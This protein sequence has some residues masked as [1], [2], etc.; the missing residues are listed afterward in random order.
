VSKENGDLFSNLAP[1]YE[2]VGEFYDLFADNTDIPFYIK[3]A[4][5]TGSPILDLAAGT[6]R[7]AFALAHDGH[8]VIA[9]D[10]SPS[11]LSTARK[12]LQQ[13]S[14]D[15]SGRITFIEGNM[16][17]FEIPEKFA[18]VIIPNSFGH[19][20]TTDA[21]VATLRCIKSHMKKDG[22]FILDLYIG[23]Q[24]YTHATFK[25]PAVQIGKYR[26]VERHGEIHSDIKRKLMRVDIQYI[27]KNIDGSILETIEVESG[28][29]LFFNKEIDS[30][31][32]QVGFKIIEEMG[33]LHGDS[34]NAES[35]RRV[36]IL[37]KST[38][39]LKAGD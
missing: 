29:A 2:G 4:R 33:S 6:G 15:I 22:L 32:E 27:I 30:L 24:Q 17:Q 16:E 1:G 3:C 7:I 20:L 18:L 5:R 36:L 11:M 13:V 35:G 31:L 25:D 34:Y 28:A 8:E 14:K 12:K 37:K 19:A 9:L 23:E 10:N 21:Q 26:T 38:D 39:K